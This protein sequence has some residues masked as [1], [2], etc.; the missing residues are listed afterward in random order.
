MISI[1]YFGKKLSDRALFIGN[2]FIPSQLLFIIPIAHGYCVAAG[3]KT[4]IF[5]RPVPREVAEHRLL[6]GILG[7]YKIIIAEYLTKRSFVGALS[8][9]TRRILMLPEAFRLAF[10]S[11]RSKLLG[12]CS[13]Y[14]VQLRHGVWDNALQSVPD[15]TIHISFLRRFM[16]AVRVLEKVR[17][18]RRIVR[19]YRVQ[20][21]FLGHTVY[22]GR[23]LVAEFRRQDVRL[24]AHAA[25]S[26]YRLDMDSDNS[27]LFMP[28]KEWDQLLLLADQ[29]Q[30]DSYWQERSIGNSTYSDARAAFEKSKEVSWQTPRNIIM[31]HIFRD[32]PFNYIDRNR[33][34][35]DYIEWI[36]YTLK[37]ISNSREEWLLKTHPSAN[38][39]GENQA[40]WLKEIIKTFLPGGLSN[41]VI[42][43][44]GDYSNIDLFQHA[45]RF[46]TYSGTA[47]LEAA[48]SGIKP[49]VISSVTLN[50]F[51]PDL[52]F[53]P[54]TQSEYA[55][56]LLSATTDARFRL[57]PSGVSD[58]KRLLH[59]REM[60]LGFASNVGSI[61]LYRGDD[62]SFFKRDWDSV[63]QKLSSCTSG[64]LAAGLS[65][66]RG[67]PRTVNLDH[68]D[69]WCRTYFE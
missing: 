29:S 62:G 33:V 10:Q 55:E 67:L 52:L 54:S 53:K 38:R 9:L 66:Q 28:R 35:S 45:K 46:V 23:G 60:I 15:G 49:I 3:I 32:S 24:Y 34:F 43:S 1:F 68:L 64:L 51:D 31:M 40:V 6:S 39:W 26:I 25:N 18:A 44:D 58:A 11:S 27:H 41:N 8:F 56:L 12:G 37:V 50:S 16:S 14:E 2:G 5:D 65:L 63:N 20:V 17:L 21:A 48:C 7:Q 42:L 30:V 69:G 36:S 59:A 22:A 57:T 4:L 61:T 47:H 19:N 13:W